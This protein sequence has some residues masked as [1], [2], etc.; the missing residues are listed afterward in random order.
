MPLDADNVHTRIRKLDKANEGL[1]QSEGWRNRTIPS[2]ILSRD[3]RLQ[4]SGL[5][6]LS[7]GSVKSEK[8]AYKGRLLFSY[9]ILPLLLVAFK[10]LL[11]V[12]S[13]I[14]VLCADCLTCS[15]SIRR[16]VC[17]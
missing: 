14:C 15:S 2:A 3:R 1:G 11:S 7:D 10:T 12:L 16:R 9:P 4:I 13:V 8:F 5:S 17:A 6:A